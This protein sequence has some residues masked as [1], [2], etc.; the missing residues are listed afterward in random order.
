MT[1]VGFAGTSPRMNTLLVPRFAR[2]MSPLRGSE[3]AL[4]FTLK[5]FLTPA[6]ADLRLVVQEHDVG[7]Y[8]DERAQ[9]A[10]HRV[11]DFIVVHV[12][13][14]DIGFGID[15]R[16]LI[17]VTRDL[18]RRTPTALSRR[19]DDVIARTAII[20]AERVV[21]RQRV[22]QSVGAGVDDEIIRAALQGEVT[23]IHVLM[24]FDH[25][26]IGET[27]PH[28][29]RAPVRTRVHRSGDLRRDTTAEMRS[30]RFCNPPSGPQPARL[31]RRGTGVRMAPS[32]K[33]GRYRTNACIDPISGVAGNSFQSPPS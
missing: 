13:R 8:I 23:L 21:I 19:I 30:R 11:G 25:R 20:E 12:R 32:R 26:A 2:T 15:E 18:R 1:G 5:I 10:F 14:R 33:L 4:K 7:S 22:E 16:V 28:G 17:F 3:A 31:R 9:C 6:F 27:Q 24:V 29:G